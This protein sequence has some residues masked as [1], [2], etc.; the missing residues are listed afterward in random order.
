MLDQLL[1]YYY[2]IKYLWL[3]FIHKHA[4]KK[5]TSIILNNTQI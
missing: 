2:F 5:N 1:N 3:R 4:Y